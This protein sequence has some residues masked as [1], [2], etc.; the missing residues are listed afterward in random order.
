SR[1]FRLEPCPFLCAMTLPHAERRLDRKRL[2][3]RDLQ[4]PEVAGGWRRPGGE[5]YF[6]PR[7][8]PDVKFPAKETGPL[9]RPLGVRYWGL[10]LGK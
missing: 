5:T 8:G 9:D 4:I 6:L 2:L 3:E 10:R 1:P 7:M